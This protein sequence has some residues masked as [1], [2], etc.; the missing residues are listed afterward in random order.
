MEELQGLT[1]VDIKPEYTKERFEALIQPLRRGE[2]GTITFI[3]KHCRKNGSIYPV[4]VNLQLDLHETHPIFVAIILDITERVRAEAALREGEQRM[5]LH[6][7]HTPLAVIEWDVEEYIITAWNRSAERIF[8]YSAKKVIGKLKVATIMPDLE[9]P[10]TKP[11]WQELPNHANNYRITKKSL[12]KDGKT[13]I[14]EWY[15]TPF[16]DSKGKVTRVAALAL[17]ITVKQRAL[18]ALLNAQEEERD[19]SLV[20]YMIKLVNH[21]L[22][23]I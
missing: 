14:C 10:E 21:L 23:S 15:A 18:E 22:P 9:N 4:E 6:I 20:I 3:T 13:I 1:P 17:D 16:K 12:T 19:E 2:K 5:A 11:F 7:E 8:G